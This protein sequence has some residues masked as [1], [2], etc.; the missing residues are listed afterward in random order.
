MGC[1][2]VKEK[3]E[4]Q[5]M[6]IK[7]ERVD[8]RTER[9][10]RIKQY[11]KLTG[12]KLTRKPIPDYYIPDEETNPTDV[13]N[14]RKNGTKISKVSKT[15]RKSSRR[16]KEESDEEEEDDNNDD[17]NN[18]D[19]NNDDDDNEDDDN[20]DDEDDDEENFRRTKNRKKN[21]SSKRH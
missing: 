4:S 21:T 12:E 14:D 19:D 16:F 15:S 17:D 3:L 10:D 6:Q 11:E 7:L 18:D 5:I 1:A 8:I 20:D 2:T 13:R 9:E